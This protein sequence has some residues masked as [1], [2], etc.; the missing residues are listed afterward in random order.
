M[1][2]KPL[3]PEKKLSEENEKILQNLI[4]TWF[5]ENEKKLLHTA[6]KAK[7]YNPEDLIQDTLLTVYEGLQ[8]IS[9]KNIFYLSNS[10]GFSLSRQANNESEIFPG[11]RLIFI[12]NSKSSKTPYWATQYYYT[13]DLFNENVNRLDSRI[14]EGIPIYKKNDNDSRIKVG[15]GKKPQ[16]SPG[17][18]IPLSKLDKYIFRKFKDVRIDAVR[19]RQTSSNSP[20]HKIPMKPEEIKYLENNYNQEDVLRLKNNIGKIIK[21]H[22]NSLNNSNCHCMIDRNNNYFYVIQAEVSYNDNI[23]Q[24]FRT[25]EFDNSEYSFN[26]NQETFYN[27][28]N[29]LDIIPKDKYSKEILDYIQIRNNITEN[30]EHLNIYNAVIKEMIGTVHQKESMEVYYNNVAN[31]FL[32]T[33]SN[34][35][36]IYNRIKIAIL[37]KLA[38][39]EI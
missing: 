14:Y 24:S 31:K 13:H 9:E 28:V 4:G 12:I 11:M 39:K 34:I 33:A 7:Y 16:S 18:F 6:F 19:K 36:T 1:T 15:C 32:E 37:T 3:L 29:N 5:K 22:G 10:S 27:E 20:N 2:E 25:N 21:V 8:K 26:Q 38:E 17:T 23:R 30:I 35:K